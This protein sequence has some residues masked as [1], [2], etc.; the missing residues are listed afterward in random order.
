MERILDA[1]LEGLCTRLANLIT[2][3]V[4]IGK[5]STSLGLRVSFWKITCFEPTLFFSFMDIVFKHDSDSL[6]DRKNGFLCGN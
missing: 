6:C 1:E 3:C 2:S 5:P 4:G